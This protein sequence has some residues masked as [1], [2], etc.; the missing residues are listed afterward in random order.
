MKIEFTLHFSN[1]NVC[2]G[3]QGGD[4]KLGHQQNRGENEQKKKKK[5]L[6][7]GKFYSQL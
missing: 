1:Q 2:G 5:T 4:L 3:K 6:L 7:P